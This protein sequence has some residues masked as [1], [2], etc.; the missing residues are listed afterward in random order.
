[1]NRT[2]SMLDRL[3]PLWAIAPGTLTHGVLAL[4]G[5]HLA[6]ADEDADRIQRSH[7]VDFAFDREDLAKLASLVGLSPA[8]WEPADLFRT[9]LRATVAARLAGAVTRGAIDGALARILDA[10]Q[11]ALG[12]RLCDLVPGGGGMVFTDAPRARPGAPVF[13]EFP[14]RSLRHAARVRPLAQIVLNNRGL[15]DAPL[16]VTLRGVAAGRTAVPVLV[17]LTTGRIVVF[18]GVVNCGVALRL[19]PAGQDGLV[20]R[21]DGRSATARITTGGGFQPGQRLA[22]PDATPRSLALARGEN[23]L[24]IFPLALYDQPSLGTGALANP[25]ADLR[26]GRFAARDDAARG[27]R[28]GHSLFEQEPFATIELRWTERRAASFR[29]RVPTG[30]A[31]RDTVEAPPDV[32]AVLGLLDDTARLLRAAGVDGRAVAAP[33]RDTQASASRGRAWNPRLPR[34]TQPSVARLAAMGALFDTTA[35]EGARF[36]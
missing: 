21:L 9:R 5:A 28:Y 33:F 23:T 17:N 12:L 8:P 14:A 4:A 31:R 16:S 6:A 36:Q 26:H 11:T 30:L 2:D 13:D 20:A 34:T 18:R 29:F 35:R 27:T 7:W 15:D 32:P 1:M 19:V 24:W 10:A 22:E 25:L 3:P